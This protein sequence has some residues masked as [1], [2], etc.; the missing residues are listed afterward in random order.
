MKIIFIFIFVLLLL[1]HTDSFKTGDFCKKNKKINCK[2][3]NCGKYYCSNSKKACKDFLEI[4]YSQ[5]S[6]QNQKIY[7]KIIN[8]IEEC[9]NKQI[10]NQWSHRLNFG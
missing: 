2:T 8:S 6:K 7:Q 5:Y 3:H 4:I 9:E 10:R 1:S